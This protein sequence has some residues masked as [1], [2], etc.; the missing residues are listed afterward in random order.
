MSVLPKRALPTE[1]P[2][3][4]RVRPQRLVENCRRWMANAGECP[5]CQRPARYLYVPMACEKP[6]ACE[7]PAC[8]KCHDLTWASTRRHGGVL[9]SLLKRERPSK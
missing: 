9:Q 1:A 5:Q 8:Q 6:V 4:R 2:T 7:K 3:A